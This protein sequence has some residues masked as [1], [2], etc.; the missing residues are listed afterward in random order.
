MTPNVSLRQWKHPPPAAVTLYLY[1]IFIHSGG[2]VQLTA[3]MYHNCINSMLVF[4]LNWTARLLFGCTCQEVFH[5][6]HTSDVD[7]N[8]S[9]TT[10][11]SLTIVICVLLGE[12]A[13]SVK[14][15]FTDVC[16]I[17][18]DHGCKPAESGQHGFSFF[19][20][21]WCGFWFVRRPWA[22]TS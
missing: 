18:Q 8:H 6:D 20:E 12:W 16:V 17:K 22:D 14:V 15:Q 3:L 7:G 2:A 21:T 19:L 10:Q 5:S 11:L 4:I 1:S 9:N 13:L